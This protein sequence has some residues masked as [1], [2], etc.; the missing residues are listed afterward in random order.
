MLYFAVFFCVVS[1]VHS[2]MGSM[3]NLDWP[4]WSYGVAKQKKRSFPL[5]VTCSSQVCLYDEGFNILS[6]FWLSWLYLL[7]LQYAGSSWDELKHIRQAV[8]FLVCFCVKINILVHL[9]GLR[10]GQCDYFRC[11]TYS[12][13]AKSLFLMDGTTIPQF[14]LL[15][16]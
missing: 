11:D 2:A 13:V 5:F 7:E 15:F 12:N 6:V 10:W 1:A 16:N 4:S 14:W 9:S 8:G 3:W